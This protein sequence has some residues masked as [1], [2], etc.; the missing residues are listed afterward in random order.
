[1]SRS[2]SRRRASP[3]REAR[4][5]AESWRSV[6]PLAADAIGNYPATG[7]SISDRRPPGSRNRHTVAGRFKQHVRASFV[8]VRHWPPA[9]TKVGG[10][11]VARTRS[12]AWH[13]RH[14]LR[15][16]VV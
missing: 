5:A 10:G 6:P 12:P 4:P 14:L 11:G 7:A 15:G 3:R 9:P 2:R 16:A 8:R 1:W 13:G